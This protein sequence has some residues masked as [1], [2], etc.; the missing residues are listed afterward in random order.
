MG[1]RSQIYVRITEKGR[2]EVNQDMVPMYYQW[3]YGE[4]MV[5]RVAYTV[6]WLKEH[7]EYYFS[8]NKRDA[9]ESVLR[10]N[11][12]MKDVVSAKNIFLEAV[13]YNEDGK[14]PS[15]EEMNDFLFFGQDNNDGKAYIDVYVDGNK[16]KI[17]YCFQ[18]RDNT[19]INM[20]ASEYMNWCMDAEE[21]GKSWLEQFAENEYHDED[22][23]YTLK[24]IRFLK[25]NAKLMN[26]KS[27]Q[28]F[29][30]AD[31]TDAFAKKITSFVRHGALHGAF[32]YSYGICAELVCGEMMKD[33][34]LDIP[35][36]Y[37]KAGELYREYRSLEDKTVHVMAFLTDKLTKDKNA[38]KCQTPDAMLDKLDEILEDMEEK[39]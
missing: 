6:E 34:Q 1:Q 39:E 29:L 35:A 2:N 30:E 22:I 17:S 37:E 4:R 25:E 23:T 18:D 11:F 9:L 31:Y 10:T 7:A 19:R 16:T 36:V 32:D 38:L 8:S 24:N 20:N 5:S 28:E 26:D 13:D 12:D 15:K 14:L 21:E 27:L 3:N 33:G